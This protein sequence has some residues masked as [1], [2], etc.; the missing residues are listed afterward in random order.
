MGNDEHRPKFKWP[1][2]NFSFNKIVNTN[3]LLKRPLLF[4]VVGLRPMAKDTTK[5]LLGRYFL[6][7]GQYFTVDN[8]KGLKTITLRLLK[9]T[10]TQDCQIMDNVRRARLNHIKIIFKLNLHWF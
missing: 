9:V 10:L 2:G 8:Y 1:T 4:T 3:G 7:N 6:F 5:Y